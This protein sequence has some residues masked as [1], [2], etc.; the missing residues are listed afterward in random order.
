MGSLLGII[1]SALLTIEDFTGAFDV[2]VQCLLGGLPSVILSDSVS[3][4]SS[5]ETTTTINTSAATLVTT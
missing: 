1:S 3:L 2:E 4:L 5:S